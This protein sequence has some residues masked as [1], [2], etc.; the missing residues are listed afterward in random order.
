[1]KKTKNPKKAAERTT[2]KKTKKLLY[3][4]KSTPAKPSTPRKAERQRRTM[5]DEVEEL[6][7]QVSELTEE[8]DQLRARVAQL[9][10]GKGNTP[11]SGV[12]KR[13]KLPGEKLIKTN[14]ETGKFQEI[15]RA[16]WDSLA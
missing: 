10:A 2:T 12:W 7:K 3:E 9:E 13:G 6:Q 1:M 4:I 8:N 14:V 11:P 16:E 15:N 5:G